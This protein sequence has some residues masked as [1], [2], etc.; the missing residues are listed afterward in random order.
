MTTTTTAASNAEIRALLSV[1]DGQRRHVLGILDGL[2]AEALRRP[3]LPSGW[4]CLGLVQHLALDVERFWFR[5]VVTGDPAAIE[6]LDDIDDAW[7][8]PSDVPHTEVLDR[9]RT[10]ADLSDTVITAAAADAPLAW[11]PHHLFG[12][13]HLHTVRDVLLHVITE[14]ACHAGHLDA[15]RELIDGRRWL[16]LT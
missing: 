12:E 1:L 6:A 15:A 3:V 16:V 2:D 10:E 9:Y 11:W 14:T 5:A 13:P 8:V 4:S 7:Q